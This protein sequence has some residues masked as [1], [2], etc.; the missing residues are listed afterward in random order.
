MM[1]F[2]RPLLELSKGPPYI[3]LLQ[4]WNCSGPQLPSKLDRVLPQLW[5]H[6]ADFHPEVHFCLAFGRRGSEGPSLDNLSNSFD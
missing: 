4:S 1:M 6:D 5:D 2:V 3:V